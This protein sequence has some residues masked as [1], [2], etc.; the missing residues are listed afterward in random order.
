LQA[1]NYRSRLD[2]LRA[3]LIIAG[4]PFDTEDVRV[5]LSVL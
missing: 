1:L 5:F 3:A 2:A 4:C